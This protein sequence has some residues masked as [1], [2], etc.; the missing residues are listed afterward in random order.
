MWRSLLLLP[1]ILLG[2][3]TH[4][5]APPISHVVIIAME[6]HSRSAVIGHAPYITSLAKTYGEATDYVN[7]AHPSLPNYAA[8]TSG[9][10]QGK[11]G[12]DCSPGPSCQFTGSSIFGQV[13]WHAYA[14][15]MVGSCRHTNT[16]EYVVRH[17][18][19][20][21]YTQMAGTCSNDDTPLSSTPGFSAQ[22]T[23]VT[24]NLCHDMHDTCGGSSVAHGDAWLKGF[25]PKVLNS[26]EYKAGTTAVFIWWDEGTSGPLPFVVVSPYTHGVSYSGKIDH[27]ATLRT[28]E[29]LLGV[30]C[31]GTA[32][33]RSNFAGAFG[34]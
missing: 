16:G 3:T 32:C 30:H 31:L 20:P 9:S 33:S 24:P 17:N 23:W 1:L 12:S 22:L 13:T 2:A 15:S 6:N 7:I 27:Y 19:P 25:L 34:L 14:E 18:P 8:V 28:V 10:T 5:A 4:R 11:V 26:A 21:Y 29:A